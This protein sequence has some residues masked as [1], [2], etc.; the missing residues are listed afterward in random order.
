MG[1]WLLG[2]MAE[3]ENSFLGGGRMHV[4]RKRCNQ[5]DLRKE[6][7]FGQINHKTKIVQTSITH[8]EDLAK[9]LEIFL[10]PTKSNFLQWHAL[11]REEQAKYYE[12]VRTES[13]FF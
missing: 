7:E 4:E 11:T 8:A 9:C 6:G 12:Q 3:D 1:N 10:D 5:S 13:N 2:C